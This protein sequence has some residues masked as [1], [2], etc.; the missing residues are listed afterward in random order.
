MKSIYFYNGSPRNKS[1]S[2]GLISS[3]IHSTYIY[4]KENGYEDII[5]EWPSKLPYP[6]WINSQGNIK[7]PLQFIIPK[8]RFVNKGV[9]LDC[10]SIDISEPNILF[11]GCKPLTNKIWYNCQYLN[12]VFKKTRIFP[13]IPI[14]KQKYILFH[15]RQ[16]IEYKQKI[17]NTPVDIMESILKD[18]KV[19]YPDHKFYKIGEKSNIDNKFDEILP[20]FPNEIWRIY[21]LIARANLFIGSESGPAYI[22]YMFETPSIILQDEQTEKNLE[23]S[24]IYNWTNK[25][26]IMRINVK[27]Y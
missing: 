1:F 9:R 5:L 10:E 3:I 20:Y 27:K 8:I 24:N 25:S 23:N 15:N 22:S 11:D 17:R 14:E 6:H 18:L 7:T 12:E 13:T 4:G 19:K 2:L 21:E 16:S 26:I